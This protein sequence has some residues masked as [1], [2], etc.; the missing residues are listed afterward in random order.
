MKKIILLPCLF[1]FQ[2]VYADNTIYKCISSS[3]EV[4]YQNTSGEKTECTKTNLASFPNVNIFKTENI[5]KTNSIISTVFNNNIE[6]KTTINEEQ[7]TRDMKRSLILTQELNEEKEQLTTVSSMLNNLKDTHSK[8]SS[9]VSQLEE[10]KISHINNINAI[11]RELSTTKNI[12]KVS[13]LKI[14]KAN[15]DLMF[16]NQSMMITKPLAVNENINI[17]P[18]TLPTFLPMMTSPVL[19][20]K[21]DMSKGQ[22]LI[23]LRNTEKKSIIPK[24]NHN[25]KKVENKLSGNSIVYSSGLS[26]MP[27]VQK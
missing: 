10:L 15:S 5:K 18:T 23:L 2:L 13:E 19:P 8:D 1:L 4:T 12:N 11:E 22:N 16:N 17:L 6:K 27:K 26:T 14:E 20:N 24:N 25:P 21:T 9:Q 7:R 3:G